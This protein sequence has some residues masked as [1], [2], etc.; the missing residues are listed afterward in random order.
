MKKVIKI[1]SYTLQIGGY[2]P[3]L[4]FP[5]TGTI[6]SG[7]FSFPISVKKKKVYLMSAVQAFTLEKVFRRK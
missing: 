6:L 5:G 4:T 7:N 3:G 1:H 2:I